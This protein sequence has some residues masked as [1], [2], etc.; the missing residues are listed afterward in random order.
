MNTPKPLLNDT[1]LMINPSE[2]GAKSQVWSYI[3]ELRQRWKRS[4]HQNSCYRRPLDRFRPESDH[5]GRC[6][7]HLSRSRNQYNT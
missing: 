4:W 1:A 7:W 2:S 6:S 3:I 5:E